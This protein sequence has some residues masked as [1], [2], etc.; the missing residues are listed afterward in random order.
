MLRSGSIIPYSI[1]LLHHTEMS[2]QLHAPAPLPPL[3]I[4]TP[5]SIGREAG[6]APKQVW[7]R[8]RRKKIPS[9][10]LPGIEPQSFSP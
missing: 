5:L 4:E 10:P 3:E 1:N 7:I 8:W 2:G 9:F 6:W